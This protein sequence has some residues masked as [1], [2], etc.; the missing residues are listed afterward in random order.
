MDSPK[1]PDP[2]ATA[3]AQTK[4]NIGAATATQEM[5][6]VDQT[7]PYGSVHYTR[8][9]ENPDGTP[10]YAA[11]STLSPQLQSLFNSNVGVAQSTAGLESSILKSSAPLLSKPLD[12]SWG[13][14]E[15][16]LDALGRKTLDPEWD[17]RS[18]DLEQSLYNRGVMPGSEAYTTAM[19][20]FGRQRGSAYDSLYLQ[21]HGSAVSDLTAE[22]TAPLNALASLRSGTQVQQPSIGTISTPTTS[23]APANISGLIQQDYQDQLQQSNATMGGLFGLGGTLLG[24]LVGGPMGASVG[25]GL[26]KGL[27]SFGGS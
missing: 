25:K 18:T 5:N 16:K 19:D 22:Y 20:E 9:G 12:L 7:T 21:G 15:E 13:A 27:M 23:V 3:A 8:T 24:G 17:K 2:Y 11:T 26:G 4:S 10:I 1:A 14:T 6:M